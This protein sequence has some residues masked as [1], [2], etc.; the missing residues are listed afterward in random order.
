MGDDVNER[1]MLEQ[2]IDHPNNKASEQRR[3]VDHTLWLAD[4]LDTPAN[5]DIVE[6]LLSAKSPGHFQ[7]WLW[8]NPVIN[9]RYMAAETLVNKRGYIPDNGIG[10][11]T[12]STIQVVFRM[13]YFVFKRRY[14]ERVH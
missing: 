12:G 3:L 4:I 9:E 5:I 10:W 2:W 7:E 13:L 6:A 8:D 11:H 1:E 14:A